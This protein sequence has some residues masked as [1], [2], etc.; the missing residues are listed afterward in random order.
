MTHKHRSMKLDLLTLADFLRLYQL[1][2]VIIMAYCF[3]VR[4]I[5]FVALFVTIASV[6]ALFLSFLP[7][8]VFQLVF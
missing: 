7:A 5:R 1:T 4:A 6:R 8:P 2:I 3:I